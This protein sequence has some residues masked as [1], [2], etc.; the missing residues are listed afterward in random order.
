MASTRNINTPGNY[1]AEQVALKQEAEYSVYKG[2]GKPEEVC[3]PGNWILS[4]R[5][6]PQVLSYNPIDIESS[7]FGI[8]STNLVD[9]QP[10]VKPEIK[11][12]PSL[13]LT[14]TKTVIVM[15]PKPANVTR[16]PLYLN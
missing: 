11:I 4:G 8:N 12:L 1:E 13:N 9:P 7:L 2:F 3:L 16:K 14:P 6:A 5:M 10:P 15:E